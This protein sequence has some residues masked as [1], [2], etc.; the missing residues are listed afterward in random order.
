MI[1]SN[2]SPK[3]PVVSINTMYCLFIINMH[4]KIKKIH[5][6][7]ACPKQTAACPAGSAASFSPSNLPTEQRHRDCLLSKQR[8]DAGWEVW[9]RLKMAEKLSEAA[10]KVASP[11]QHSHRPAQNKLKISPKGRCYCSPRLLSSKT[12]SSQ[13]FAPKQLREV[14]KS[15]MKGLSFFF[16]F[17]KQSHSKVWS[18][19]QCRGWLGATALLAEAAFSLCRR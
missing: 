1:Y 6:N 11:T 7:K 4:L 15:P 10:G 14:L 16:F 5:S 8:L 13:Y 2:L 18:G 17:L 19:W 3:D 9:S 12:T